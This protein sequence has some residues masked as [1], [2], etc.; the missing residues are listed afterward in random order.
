MSTAEQTRQWRQANPAHVLWYQAQRRAR[1]KGVPF[2]I[3][4]GEMEDLLSLSGWSCLYCTTPVGTFTGRGARPFSATVD[5]LIPSL[6]Y[7][8]ENTVIACHR[9]NSTKAEHTPATLRAW[10]DNLDAIIQ[11]RQNPTGIQ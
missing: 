4:E 5:R 9:C 11:Q 10:A 6:G 2:T 3:S 7:T 1:V 8:R